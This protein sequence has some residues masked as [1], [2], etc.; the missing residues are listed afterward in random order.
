MWGRERADVWVARASDELVVQ[1]VGLCP[2]MGEQDKEMLR[3]AAATH[4]GM[5]AGE[6][7]DLAAMAENV[8]EL[9]ERAKC[10]GDRRRQWAF[11]QWYGWACAALV[12]EEYQGPEMPEELAALP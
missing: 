10:A 2:W 4:F 8:F 11:E 1:V 12:G 9:A 3:V 7:V 6:E 5:V